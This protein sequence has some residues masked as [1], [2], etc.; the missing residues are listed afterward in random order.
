MEGFSLFLIRKKSRLARTFWSSVLALAD[1][2]KS[3]PIPDRRES[4]SAVN[5]KFFG[6][7][8]QPI[9]LQH[10]LIDGGKV[11]SAILEDLSLKR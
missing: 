11:S 8:Y 1:S 9:L 2:L 3:R 10:D 6:A 7:K 4:I 5:M